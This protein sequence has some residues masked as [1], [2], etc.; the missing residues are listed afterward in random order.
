VRIALRPVFFLA[1]ELPAVLADLIQQLQDRQVALGE[2][3]LDLAL[4]AVPQD[5]PGVLLILGIQR[6]REL[7]VLPDGHAA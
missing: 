4:G 5:R 2:I 1:G 6:D 3:L 7:R